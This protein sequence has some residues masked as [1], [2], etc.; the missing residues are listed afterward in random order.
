MLICTIISR[1]NFL[2]FWL[3]TFEPVDLLTSFWYVGRSLQYGSSLSIKV[4][5]QGHDSKR[6]SN[7]QYLLEKLV[8]RFDFG[9]FG[10]HANE[11]MQS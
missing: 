6:T 4:T 3:I 2:C 9:S 10:I 11:P 5:G 7:V 1:I 8:T